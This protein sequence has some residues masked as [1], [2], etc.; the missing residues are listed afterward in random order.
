MRFQQQ[1]DGKRKSL[2]TKQFKSKDNKNNE[3]IK[4]IDFG[5]NYLIDN[6]MINLN[7]NEM[8]DAIKKLREK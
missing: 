8:Q 5:Y 4:C 2:Y 3:I 6:N 1:I 7:K